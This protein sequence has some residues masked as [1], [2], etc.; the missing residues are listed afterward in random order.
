[1]T[2]QTATPTPTSPRR[3]PADALGAVSL[4][5]D[6]LGEAGEEEL[7]LPVVPGDHPS[8]TTGLPTVLAE[9]VEADLTATFFVEGVNAEDHPE[10]VRS[11]VEAGHECAY[12]A[13][14]H[15]DWSGLTDDEERTNL[16]RGLAAM[17]ALGVEARGFRP[18]GGRLRDRTLD[19]L[20]EHGLTHCSPA[21]SGLGIEETVLLPFTWRCVDAYHLLPQFASLREH[22][23]G[24]DVAGGAEGV[25]EAMIEAVD[26]AIARGGHATLVLHPTLIESEHQ[27]VRSVLHHIKLAVQ[28]GDLWATRC[29]EVA[30]WIAGHPDAFSEPTQLDTTTS[31]VNPS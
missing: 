27:A 31:W 23:D 22:V 18:P 5:F 24:S 20:R 9:L 10:A 12:H 2:P 6:N 3:W 17:R 26:S 1:M 30:D 16:S 15:E 7:G 13:W 28:R 29:D 4:T 19:L 11:I 8:I 21:G 25:A 14:H